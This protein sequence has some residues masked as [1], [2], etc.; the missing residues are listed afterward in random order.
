MFVMQRGTAQFRRI[1]WL[2]IGCFL[3]RL[4]ECVEIKVKHGDEVVFELPEI[5]SCGQFSFLNPSLRPVFVVEGNTTTN[6]ISP[7]DKRA[8]VIKTDN[9]FKLTIS[10]STDS[11]AG[12]YKV[13][14]SS[15]T[16]SPPCLAESFY[17]TVLEATDVHMEPWETWSFC[18]SQCSPNRH[19]SRSR[20]CSVKGSC[21][22]IGPMFQTETCDK[23]AHC[24]KWSSWGS[25]GSCSA[26][27]GKGFKIRKRAC[28]SGNSSLVKSSECRGISTQSHMCLTVCE[29]VGTWTHWSEWSNCSQSCDQ[30]STSRGTRARNRSCSTDSGQ[31][32]VAQNC[33]GNRTEEEFCNTNCIVSTPS[34]NITETVH[35]QG[36]TDDTTETAFSIIPVIA[37]AACALIIIIILV[38]VLVLKTRVQRRRGSVPTLRPADAAHN[39]RKKLSKERRSET[40][41]DV[42]ETESG[43]VYSELNSSFQYPS[44]EFDS[45]FSIDNAGF[46]K[47]SAVNIMETIRDE[48]ADDVS[49]G[50]DSE[51]DDN[52]EVTGTF[53][54]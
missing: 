54:N 10:H 33:T 32:V 44:S 34:E 31:H 16:L 48:D 41:R 1:H 51:F 49:D 3:F 28:L 36:V 46:T 47:S 19:R 40:P 2:I 20:Q 45:V 17:V 50:Y 21:T 53:Y 38:I 42:V 24:P 11:D 9:G 7:Y 37:G 15:V 4:Y 43:N 12:T 30:D 29:L 14:T 25:W 39:R 6:L 18:I 26:K 13:A 52:P 8:S 5:K 22:D 35:V 27:C 23:A